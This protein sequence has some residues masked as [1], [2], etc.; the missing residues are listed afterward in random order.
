MVIGLFLTGVAQ[1]PEAYEREI[2]AAAAA[3]EPPKK[4]AKKAVAAD[5]AD[6]VDDD[7]F[8]T[9]GKGGKQFTFSAD[10]IFKT[11]QAVL[12]LRGRKNTDRAEQV[13]I[14]EK[15]L[16]ICATTYQ[17]IRVLLTLVSLQF[18]YNP[19]AVTHM[20]AES[21]R[22]ARG[23][24]DE[25]LAL[26]AEQTDYIVKEDTE[27]YDDQ[28]ERVPEAGKKL[29][30]RGSIGSLLDRLDDEF[31]K[32]LQ[33]TDPHT[34]EYIER[35]RDEKPLYATIVRSQAYFEQ[36]A[37]NEAMG[38]SV[39]RRLEHVYCKVRHIRF[40]TRFCPSMPDW[41]TIG[42]AAGRSH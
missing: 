16:S 41:V 3:A 11:L 19:G 1:D 38:K 24:L 40:E 39:M 18:D 25:L 23:R 27:D 34:A 21:W 28:E 7:D 32:A 13:R 37:L 5:G 2:E 33:N 26:L 35:L 8:T 22:A 42:R 31:T 30:V 12:E 17:R 36:A 6:A 14:L 15:L 29:E 20:S 10:S 9:V 4:A